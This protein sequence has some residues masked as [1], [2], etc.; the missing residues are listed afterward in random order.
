[1]IDLTDTHCHIH[2]IN[3]PTGESQTVELWSKLEGGDVSSVVARAEEGGVS[4]LITVGCTL[5]DSKLAIST[6][7]EYD[8]VWATIGI[9]PHEAKDYAGNQANLEAFAGL[10]DS[11]KVVAIGECGLDYFYNHSDPESQKALLRFQLEL[12]NK[13][14]LPVIFHV[15][16]AFDDFWPILADFKNTKGVLHSYTDSLANLSKA[17]E[18]GLYIGV[19]G[20]ATFAKNPDLSEVYRQIPI[21]N[22]VLETDSPFLTPSPLRGNINEPKNVRLVA[23]YLSSL[24][25]EN[26]E[27]LA[28]KTTN[29]ARQLFSV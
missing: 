14:D 9:H 11:N 21:D 5:E 3:Q 17:M 19:N 16:E 20:I 27:D 7:S 1:M 22:L 8:S 13:H 10:A 18:L 2:S 23:E 25:G 4:R 15:R 12:A 6:A 24:R 28:A 29:N 26:L